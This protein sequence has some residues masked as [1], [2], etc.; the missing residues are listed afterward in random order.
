VHPNSPNTLNASVFPSQSPEVFSVSNA[1]CKPAPLPLLLRRLRPPLRLH[2]ADTSAKA[3]GMKNMPTAT[4]QSARSSVGTS[5]AWPVLAWPNGFLL[6]AYG[7]SALCAATGL[8][9]I[10]VAWRALG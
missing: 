6:L 1:K 7:V 2:L 10:A 8:A 5:L 4:S 3:N 9:R